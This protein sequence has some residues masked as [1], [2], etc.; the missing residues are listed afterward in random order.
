M[1]TQ[2]LSELVLFLIFFLSFL[3]R[4]NFS[5]EL[6]IFSTQQISFIDHKQSLKKILQASPQFTE[7]YRE[8]SANWHVFWLKNWKLSLKI[9]SPFSGRA[10]S[11]TSL[12]SPLLEF[13]F[14]LF[15]D[16][17]K[18]ILRQKI[19]EIVLCA[20]YPVNILPSCIL[21][22]RKGRCIQFS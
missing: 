11:A 13:G 6:I 22:S 15:F 18:E 10:E 20:L 5:F 19:R 9:N 2:Q 3:S 14:V 8:K 4:G 21:N 12:F 1:V 17:L 7:T 16:Q